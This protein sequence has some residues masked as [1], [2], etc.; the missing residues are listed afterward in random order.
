M[1]ESLT[2]AIMCYKTDTQIKPVM[3]Q[4]VMLCATKKNSIGILLY[5]I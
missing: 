4:N 1:W 5:G 3:Q 2:E